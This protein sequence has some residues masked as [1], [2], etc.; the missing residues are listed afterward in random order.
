MKKL[1]LKQLSKRCNQPVESI[2]E[3]LKEQ[4]GTISRQFGLLRGYK[5]NGSKILAVAHCDTVQQK[6]HFVQVQ[7]RIYCPKLDDRL[8]VYTILDYLPSLGVVTDILLTD[9]EETMM[10]TARFFTTAKQYNWIVEF[11]RHGDDVATY[12][13]QWEGYLDEYFP[14]DV[15]GSYSDIVELDHM[16]CN[17]LNIGVG[18]EEEHSLYSYFNISTY[19][20]QIRRFLKFHRETKNIHFPHDADLW[21]DDIGIV[22]TI[23]CPHCGFV[24]TSQDTITALNGY[25][26]PECGKPVNTQIYMGNRIDTPKSKLT[27]KEKKKLKKYYRQFGYGYYDSGP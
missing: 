14:E 8:G 11:D 20:A 9:G 1:D 24:F 21:A 10:T 22:E 15:R 13:Y 17:A 18:Y 26:C 23:I 27:K 3:D 5:D 12:Q 19:I 4:G 6:N 7:D 16:G 2:M 25:M